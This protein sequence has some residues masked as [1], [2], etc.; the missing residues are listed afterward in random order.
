MHEPAN[1]NVDTSVDILIIQTSKTQGES[2]SCICMSFVSQQPSEI[3]TALFPKQSTLPSW[4]QANQM[5]VFHLIRIKT[6]KSVYFLIL[7]FNGIT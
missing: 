6:E 2:T 4:K 7:V 1:I 5:N 3:Q